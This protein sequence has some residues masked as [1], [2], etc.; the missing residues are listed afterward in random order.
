MRRTRSARLLAF[1]AALLMLSL[2]LPWSHQ[3]SRAFLA[4]WGTASVLAG[5]PRDPS[6][7]QVY[8]VADVLLALVAAG[9]LALA[10][11]GGRSLRNVLAVSLALATAFTVRA[12][13]HP[14]TN[15]AVV[16]D[17]ST[18]AWARDAPRPGAGEWVAL[19]ALAAG[20]AGVALCGAP[21]SRR[22]GAVR[23]GKPRS[24][25]ML[26]PSGPPGAGPAPPTADGRLSSRPAPRAPG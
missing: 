7:W 23:R 18:G 13:V 5:V 1:A 15:G 12:I 11:T 6:A 14:P 10:L 17:P 8:A 25:P 2:F 22:R 4:R 21:G 16:F 3:F 24:A 26:D 20:A 9:L 19:A